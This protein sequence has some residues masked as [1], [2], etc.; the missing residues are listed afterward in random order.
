MTFK[1]A[2]VTAF[3]AALA[4]GIVTAILLPSTAPAPTVT[5]V[6][7]AIVTA[8]THADPA[9][10]TSTTATRQRAGAWSVQSGEGPAWP[11]SAAVLR[12]ILRAAA[13]LSSL[14][15]LDE[16]DNAPASVRVELTTDTGA[17]RVFEVLS[18][19]IG[20]KQTVRLDGRVLRAP[21]QTVALLT[22]LPSEWRDIAAFPGAGPAT[23]RLIIEQPGSRIE[24]TR[25]GGRWLI[26]APVLARADTAA[27]DT[28]IGRIASTRID[29]FETG[30]PLLTGL[31]DPVFTVTV[32]QGDDRRRL[33]FG[34]SA[35]AG[36][37]YRYASPDGGST[38]FVVDT[39]LLRDLRLDAAP[40]ADRR[41]TAVPA[42]DILALRLGG[43][44]RYARTLR[45]WEGNGP[46][47]PREIVT[48][49]T[50]DAD[51]IVRFTEPSGW[52]HAITLT[53][54][55]ASREPLDVIEIGRAGAVLVAKTAMPGADPVYYE[56]P[57]LAPAA[58]GLAA[59]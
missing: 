27:V 36:G 4:A 17:V 16:T 58:L 10:G 12:E 18:A 50:A 37:L 1:R 8:I 6:A 23:D 19:A 9:A 41:V 49:L 35:D 14:E 39:T 3:A 20:G 13:D 45:G 7:P 32:A 15:P 38:T 11:G 25:T 24:I 40:Y 43:D 34:A 2:F 53:L 31:Q 56:L 21:A 29:R 5:P 59:E 57:S 51:S 26:V 52:T 47:D 22:L 33:D 30:D 28:A 48:H 46:V 54:E 44:D 42:A 55:N